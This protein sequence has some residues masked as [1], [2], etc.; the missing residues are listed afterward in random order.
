MMLIPWTEQK[1]HRVLDWIP[2]MPFGRTQE[3]SYERRVEGSGNWLIEHPEFITWRESLKST[4]LWV[5]GKAGSGKSH[6]A[7]RVI[8]AMGQDESVQA[9]SYCSTTQMTTPLTFDLVL[10]SLLCQLYQRL[11][12]EVDID[13]LVS[14]AQSREMPQRSELKGWLRDVCAKLGSCYLII[15]GLDECSHFP[16]KQFED[17][18]G[19]LGDLA[20]PTEL[21]T[22]RLLVFSRP[23]YIPIARAFSPFPSIPVDH[24]NNDDDIRLYVSREVDEMSAE[25][26]LELQPE[27]EE[28][29]VMLHTNAG[30]TF[31][32]VRLKVR[33]IKETGSVEDMLEA[34]QDSTE[35]LDELYEQAINKILC[36]SRPQINRALKAL[37][38]VANSYRLLSKT[39]LLEALSV[40]PGRTGLS[41][42]QRIGRDRPIATE[43]ADLLVEVDGYYKLLHTS[44][45]D[46]LQ[47]ENSILPAAYRDLQL[48]AHGLM[49]ETCLTYL[50]FDE[51][52]TSSITTPKELDKLMVRYPLLE[53]ASTLWGQHFATATRERDTKSLVSLAGRFLESDSAVGLSIKILEYDEFEMG[54]FG[55]PGKPTALHLLSILNLRSLAQGLPFVEK[56]LNCHDEFIHLPIDYAMIYGSLDMALWILDQYLAELAKG[57]DMVADMRDCCQIQLIHQ[58]IG[59]NWVDAVRSLVS[60]G[61]DPNE[62]N[63]RGDSQLCFAIQT[64]AASSTIVDILLEAGADF[65]LMGYE[66]RTALHK[67]AKNSNTGIMQKLLDS[68]ADPNLSDAEGSTPL[69][70]AAKYGNV[71]VHVQKL[72]DGGAD[73]NLTNAKGLTALHLAALYGYEGVMQ[74]LIDGGADPNLPDPEGLTPLH[75]AVGY[76]SAEL[77]QK[78]LDGGSDPNLTDAGGRTPLLIA[79]KIGNAEVVQNLLN[80]GANVRFTCNLGTALHFAAGVGSAEVVEILIRGGLSVDD[81]A[82]NGA[83]PLT[84]ASYWGN[85]DALL[86]LLDH[87]ADVAVVDRRPGFHLPTGL[88]LAVRKRNLD[89]LELLLRHSRDA[90]FV[91]AVDARGETPL[92]SALWRHE[93]DI[94]WSLLKGGARLDLEEIASVLPPRLRLYIQ[95][96]EHPGEEDVFYM[97]VA[98]MPGHDDGINWSKPLKDRDTGVYHGETTRVLSLVG[99]AL[100][101]GLLPCLRDKGQGQENA[102]G[103]ARILD[104]YDIAWR[105]VHVVLDMDFGEDISWLTEV[106]KASLDSVDYQPGTKSESASAAHPGNMSYL[107]EDSE[108]GE[109]VGTPEDLIVTST[110]ANFARNDVEDRYESPGGPATDHPPA[111]P[112]STD[113]HDSSE[114]HTGETEIPRSRITGEAIRQL[115]YEFDET[116]YFFNIRGTLEDVSPRQRKSTTFCHRHRARESFYALPT[117]C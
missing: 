75:R 28:I 17:L 105:L 3:N 90:A 76:G 44:L 34:L 104:T 102:E 35:G 87:G 93:W 53:Y 59:N 82:P 116:E 60:L 14:R 83:T 49:A 79:A 64:E 99:E 11:P 66:G 78:L 86:V 26:M 39:Q 107:E 38:W 85:L 4:L 36:R 7:A 27:Y 111:S 15:D 25:D 22:V 96:P 56:L 70:L 2:S 5:H 50:A 109:F 20:K 9:F 61:L 46:F 51:F 40:K 48:E 95:T 117:P 1:R 94:A 55:F 92:V 73:P 32:W 10:G 88:H 62:P 65:A 106:R 91:D 67:A 72:L 114:G 74:M 58:A 115:G 69:H 24:G 18:C 13:S 97:D 77:V 103:L 37:L 31:L 63:W 43:C 23:N 68:G 16:E 101:E 54:P 80:G 71:G 84:I 108:Q 100:I 89:V 47:S 33:D 57:K 21:S 8:H 113:T 52:Q 30:S 19:F 112:A 110:G 42:S 29:K 41:D 45:R 6:L 81:E 12:L 98:A